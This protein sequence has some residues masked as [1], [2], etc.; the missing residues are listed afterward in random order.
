[1][2][3]LANVSCV[4]IEGRGL[5]IEGYTGSGKSSLALELID[6][7]AILIGDDGVRLEQRGEQ[8][9]A[10]PPPNITGKL[11][12]RG[13]G[14][15]LIEATSAPLALVLTL[16]EVADRLPEPMWVARDSIQLP[17]LGFSA[18]RPLAGLRA[19]WALR[20]HGL[21]IDGGAR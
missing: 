4:S 13:V 5:L 11:E 19:E 18:D 9:W 20:L 21:P 7:G 10:H 16:D 12:I 3:L 14:I 15:I 6:R 17:R 1:M 2:S 8:L